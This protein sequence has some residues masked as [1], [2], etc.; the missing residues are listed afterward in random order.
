MTLQKQFSLSVCG[1][2]FIL[3]S[4]L[5]IN[6][7]TQT[8]QIL[9]K[10]HQ[11]RFNNQLNA[12]SRLI[13]YAPQTSI[14]SIINKNIN[15]DNHSKISIQL[16][17][18]DH[19][20]KND[21]QHSPLM[22][23]QWFYQQQL[24]ESLTERRIIHFKGRDFATVTIT[25]YPVQE[26]QQLWQYCYK[27]GLLLLTVT[28]F[29][30]LPLIIIIRKKLYPLEKLSLR[31][32]DISKKQ[33]SIY[34]PLQGSK[35]IQSIIKTMNHLTQQ[36]DTNF[37]N[38]THEARKIQEQAYRD[39]ISGLGNRTFF[40]H[41]L[42][43][44][45]AQSHRGGIILLRTSL[46]NDCHHQLG[47][48][49]GEK[50]TK[51]I[52]QAI[53]NT[54]TYHDI[55][56]AHLSVSEF[57]VL[58]PEITKDKL[59]VIGEALLT[60]MQSFNHEHPALNNAENAIG[61]LINQ[62]ETTSTHILAALD[63]TVSMASDNPQSPILLIT[64]EEELPT[65][66]KLEWKQ[67][68]LDAIEHN[69]F[70]YNNQQVTLQNDEIHHVELF[71][72]IKKGEHYYSAR[73]FLRPLEDLSIGHIFDRHVIHYVF[74]YLTQNINHPPIAINIT[75]SSIHD[76][77]FI[78]W[79]YTMMS[80]YGQL[81]DRVYFELP[82]SSF[83][84]YPDRTQLFCSSLRNQQFKF[85]IDN[86]GRHFQSD[87]YLKEFKPAYVKID[88]AYTHELNDNERSQILS[89]IC[90]IAHGLNIM[91]IS[92]RVETE[93]Q[94]ERLSELF[95]TGYQ[96]FINEDNSKKKHSA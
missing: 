40:I 23:P 95:V 64:D 63:N 41:Q 80:E 46:I 26:Y 47:Y 57:A 11:Y 3:L 81:K 5:I 60:I 68:L 54:V 35:E 74:H 87:N 96:G 38:Q 73:Q 42:N 49:A 78:N 76:S 48:E 58:A 84:R 70:I 21:Y 88:F 15:S 29:L 16:T 44:W 2:F 56:I 39:P 90:R 85:G 86:Y 92:T 22:I 69:Y 17:N 94:L 45:L 62:K 65:L 32:K 19:V 14:E 37:K 12:L 50:L 53:S 9:N 91:T 93:T 66:G 83:V 31:C 13:Q 52:A 43:S 82:E 71:S 34:F 6:Q 27:S 18:T 4:I 1:S 72:A 51:N 20:I 33:Y 75:Q 24:L 67:L 55:T 7:Y 61:L 8:I 25:R 89:S 79:L 77:G 30:L 59:K 28:I 36:L 10:Q